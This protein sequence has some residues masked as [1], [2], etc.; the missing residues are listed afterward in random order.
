[1]IGQTLSHYRI[2]EKVGEGGMGVLYRALDT[3]LD[4]TVA[5]KV[6]RPEAVGDAERQRRFV[7]EA[8]AAS[9]LNHPN[10]VVVHDI[11]Q[12]ALNGSSVAFIAME[13][14]EGQA[15]D[16]LMGG[17]RL[18]VE[19]ALDYAIQVA[20]AL[21]AAHEAGIIHRDVKPANVMVARGEHVKVLDFGLAK[22]TERLTS[23]EGTP[24]V[25]VGRD[26]PT[27]TAL[28]LTREG[29][30]VGTPAYMSPEQAEGRTV[31]ARS[32]VFSL[33]AMLYEMLAGRR[34]FHGDSYLS[35]LTA[36]LRDRPT[37]LRSL[38]SEIPRELER[39]VLRCL[40]KEREARYGSAGELLHDL[41]A[42]RTALTTS[43]LRIRDVLTRPRHL[44]ALVACLL[45]VVAAAGWIWR[46]GAGP[47]WSRNVALPEI[48]RLVG[49]QDYYAA[50]LLARQAQRYVPDDVGVRRFY[51]DY[52]FPFTLETD[53]PGVDLQMKP[54]RDPNAPWEVVGRTPLKDV[55]LPVTNLRFRMT[56]PG[57]ESL[58]V[59]SEP[60]GPVGRIRRLILDRQ[61]QTPPGMVRV[62]G[63]PH[64]Y[65]SLAATELADFWIDQYEVTNRQYKDFLD[66]GAYRKRDHWTEPFV[67]EGRVLPWEEA[68]AFFRDTTGRPG[69]ATW[70]QGT[71]PEGHGNFPVSGV[72]WYEAAAYAHYAGKS[73]PTVYHWTK[74][75][76]MGHFADILSLSN[77][78]EKGPAAV[79]SHQGL[80]PFGAYDMA[81]NVKE[82]CWNESQGKRYIMGAGWNEPSY[83]FQDADAQSPW[84]RLPNYGFRCVKHA[85]AVAPAQLA[86]IDVVKVNRDY[87]AEKPATDEVFRIYRDFYLYD[88][89]PLNARVESVEPAELWREERISFDAAYG[90]ERVLAHLFLP[91]N[92]HP[93]YQTVI[94]VPSGDAPR[95]TSS[96]NLR[97]RYLDIVLRSGRALM[98]PIYKATY[99][100]RL[101]APPS[102]PRERRDV[103][104]QIAKDFGRSLDYLETRTDVD[105]DKMAFYGISWGAGLA[106]LL[107]AGEGRVKAA[108]LQGGGL[109]LSK[110][111]PEVDAFNFAPR[112]TM[113]VLM[114]NGRYDFEVPLEAS[115]KPLFRLL[116]TPEKDKRHALFDAGHADYPMTG[117]IKEL[118]DWLDRYLGSVAA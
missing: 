53:P 60:S 91:R 45:V 106:P 31:D 41:L 92:G 79:G 105:H 56:K 7:Q 81:G 30:L 14:V 47:R 9:A 21:S 98:Y 4:R 34:P 107:L 66:S 48:A 73:L 11:D 35:T 39:V 80:S 17:S 67:K 20:R 6:L 28:P 38:R 87:A 94:Y 37:S 22:L 49:R 55:R 54:Y 115:Q 102:G 93:P 118:L 114:L 57:F 99:E 96:A 86:A 113:P 50:F 108:I 103:A 8:K 90:N 36:I 89:T 109:P 97:M 52:T 19:N 112:V 76:G 59:G 13:F 70:E 61:G 74:A 101:A 104:I 111:L 65:R 75:A 68:I 1:M 40:A 95:L 32:D 51:A 44:A 84:G 12:A 27:A 110:P 100:R 82:W 63:G 72:S 117:L 62:P 77:F 23:G 58:E 3:R 26:S 18:S 29:V 24:T 83:M 33:G 69:P 88:R 16:A 2:L 25:T 42:C 64:Q 10:I 85:A 78:G 5:I 116:G 71:Y 46:R 15:L 43:A